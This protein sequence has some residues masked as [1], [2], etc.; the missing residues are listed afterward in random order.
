MRNQQDILLEIKQLIKKLQ[1]VKKSKENEDEKNKRKEI[2]A[3][4]EKR[5]HIIEYQNFKPTRYNI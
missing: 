3:P 5:Q 1:Q 4:P 2:Y